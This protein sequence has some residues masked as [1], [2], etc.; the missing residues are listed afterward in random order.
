MARL[1]RSARGALIALG[2]ALLVAAPAA[3]A[4]PTRTVHS[5]RPGRPLSQLA[6]GASS[7]SP[8]TAAAEQRVTEFS[9]GRE[10][11]ETHYIDYTMSERR[12]WQEVRDQFRAPRGGPVRRRQRHHP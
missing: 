9:D 5:P 7:T 6:P 2:L 4:Q 11:V 10:A 12:Q 1:T 3:A 8:P